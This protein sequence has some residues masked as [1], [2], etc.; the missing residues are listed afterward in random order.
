MDSQLCPISLFQPGP[1]E[2]PIGWSL[3]NIQLPEQELVLVSVLP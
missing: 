3:Q 1:F 2:G